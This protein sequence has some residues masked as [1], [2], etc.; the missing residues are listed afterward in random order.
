M[1]RKFWL[2]L[3]LA[4]GWLTMIAAEWRGPGTPGDAAVA[5]T[6]VNLV[7]SELVVTVRVPAGKRR[8]TL[9]SRPRLGLG[10]WTPRAVQWSEAAGELSFRLPAGAGLEMLRAREEDDAEVGLPAAF[11]AGSRTF[12]PGLDSSA[13]NRFVFDGLTPGSVS[14]VPEIVLDDSAAGGTEA[15]AVVESDIWKLD[16]GTLYF[17][18]QQ[19]GLQIVDVGNP[20]APVLRGT[21]P[22]AVW[23]EQ[24]YRLPADTGDGTVWLALLAQG[25]CD[26]NSEVLLVAV[27]NGQPTLT[28]R[29][30]VP[31]QVRESRLVGD[32]LYLATYAWSQPPPVEV[33][34]DAGNVQ[35]V[36]Q[37]W[38]SRTIVSALDLANPAEPATR[39]PVEV[40]A[41]PDAI[42]ATDRFLFVAT[43][44]T[45]TPADNVRLPFWAV[46]GNHGVLVFDISDPRGEIV[47]A[48]ALPTEG[49]VAD[50]F[51]L[52]LDGS[53]MAVVSQAGGQGTWVTRTNWIQGQPQ[54]FSDWTWEPP[55]AVLE[56]FSLANPA[57]PVRLA[58]LTLVTNESVFGTR[59][60]GRRAY[61]VT[62]RQVDPLWIVDLSDPAHPEIKGE[63]EVPGWSNYLHPLGDRLLAMGVE[64]GRAALSLFDVADPAR[65]ALLNKVFLGA[66]WSWS[67]ANNDEKALAVFPDAGLVLV[68]WSGQPVNQGT[69]WFQ[70]MQ[71]VD[72]D[73]TA[74][75]LTARGV[76]EHHLQARRATLLGG[77][78][79]SLSAQELL[80]ADITDRDAPAVVAELPLVRPVDRV[81]VAGDRLLQLR[82]PQG[83]TDPAVVTLTGAAT[84]DRALATLPLLSLPVVGADVHEGYLFVL[85][86]QP[87]TQ[88][89]ESHP[90]TNIVVIE[91]AQP[92][93]LEPVTNTTV[94]SVPQ[95]PLIVDTLVWRTI[96]IPPTPTTP[97]YVTN[98]WVTRREEIPQPDLLVTN[99]E[100]FHRWVAQP[101]LLKTNEVIHWATQ[102]IT[103]PGESALSVVGFGA[104][105]LALSGQTRP[106]LPAGIYGQLKPL[107]PRAGLL[108]WSEGTTA[109]QP[110]FWRGG[111]GIWGPDLLVADIVFPGLWWPWW[112][113]DSTRS[114][115]AFEVSDPAAPQLTSVTTLGQDSTGD[116]FS[117]A[118]AADDLLFL[119]R[120]VT[121]TLTPGERQERGLAPVF[122]A[123]HSDFLE[124]VDYTDAA[125]PVVRAL[126]DL[127][128]TLAGI[129]HGGRLIYTEASEVLADASGTTT[130]RLH[131]LAYDGVAASLVDSLGLPA[132]WPRPVLVRDNGQV[133]IGRP[134]ATTGDVPALEA[135]ALTLEG[136]FMRQATLPTGTPVQQVRA[137]DDVLVAETG[138]RFLFLSP[139]SPA[140]LSLL[141]TGERPC[142][143][144]AELTTGAASATTGLWLAR[145]FNGLWHVPPQR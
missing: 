48:G 132:N 110:W 13:N 68:P 129:S 15:R 93:R 40:A 39:E 122:F 54:V 62:F 29:L 55:R 57:E 80:T 46:A 135:W 137:F 61:V 119:S 133:L 83:E 79:L 106:E 118:F 74:G 131:A 97:G 8:I 105:S 47:Q 36:Y 1:K 81:F 17:F 21:L 140:E 90:V 126:A 60:D 109:Y 102:V 75:R 145:G 142:S 85:Q 114:L 59:F 38:T 100:V 117:E 94:Q 124:V 84:P 98:K 28:Q 138:D 4:L 7:G 56:T 33:R 23:G 104:D 34:D 69:G 6:G 24:M 37:P 58:G 82:Y 143:L 96:T 67:E 65:P 103:I 3:G 144:G 116:S 139:G 35:L 95:P 101:S 49:R 41:S 9:E 14:G 111:P 92:P 130:N 27:R 87:E 32:A 16:G 5:I 141:G 72:L 123:E 78:V 12:A 66:G 91:E 2:A 88:R 30:P 99:V 44:G 11:F 63:L 53:S 121:R 19:R 125:N 89:H 45:T 136:R 77:R 22:L 50:K 108:V 51:K 127:P 107:W 25:S 18:N 76:I 86:H 42:M 31:G 71:L 70:G 113:G 52:H 64:G 120:R 73:L 134:A 20:D 26:N 115:V 10:A 112:G 128:G 43:T